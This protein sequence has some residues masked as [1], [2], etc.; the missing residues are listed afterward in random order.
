MTDLLL[1]LML[2]KRWDYSDLEPH[3]PH[4]PRVEWDN[5]EFQAG[6]DSR[7][8]HYWVN[9]YTDHPYGGSVTSRGITLGAAIRS[10][11]THLEAVLEE[12]DA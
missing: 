8:D 6:Q 1:A 7:D 5:F 11:R 12:L 9:V 3:L 10:A 4:K 2:G